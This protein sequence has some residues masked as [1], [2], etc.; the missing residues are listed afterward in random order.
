V[1][2]QHLCNVCYG[3]G[4]TY[5]QRRCAKRYKV[6]FWDSFDLSWSG[7]GP[8]FDDLHEAICK[9]DQMQA[10]LPPANKNYKNCGEHYGVIDL[11]IGKEVYCGRQQGRCGGR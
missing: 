7:L 3:E 8:G 4:D 10:E 5:T 1:T 11:D 2:Q 6:D 9:C